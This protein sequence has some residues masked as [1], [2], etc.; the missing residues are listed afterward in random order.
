MKIN[1]SCGF[2]IS[3]IEI[4]ALPGKRCDSMADQ[5]VFTKESFCHTG[6]AVLWHGQIQVTQGPPAYL[7][8]QLTL[9]AGWQR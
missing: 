2:L 6:S 8:L 5:S 7:R 4:R 3:F 1:S 9:C